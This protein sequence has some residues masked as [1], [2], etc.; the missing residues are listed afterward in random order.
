MFRKLPLRRRSSH[1][2][3]CSAEVNETV[4]TMKNG[5]EELQ[6]MASLLEAEVNN[7]I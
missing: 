3:L 2:A 6:K 1:A 7:S 5:D 4:E